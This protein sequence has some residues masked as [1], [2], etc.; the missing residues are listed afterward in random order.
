VVINLCDKYAGDFAIE[1]VE[2]G[3]WHE[4]LYNYDS[5]VEGGVLRDVLAESEVKIFIKQ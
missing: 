2:D 4:Y 1:N 5:Q 3:T